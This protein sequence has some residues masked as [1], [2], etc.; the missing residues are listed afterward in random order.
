MNNK[1][2]YKLTNKQT[3]RE[4]AFLGKCI[5]FAPHISLWNSLEISNSYNLKE[6][7]NYYGFFF[8][9]NQTSKILNKHL[10]LKYMK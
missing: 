4:L 6:I 8:S 10:H 2:K 3:N 9:N 1:Y 7:K 5:T